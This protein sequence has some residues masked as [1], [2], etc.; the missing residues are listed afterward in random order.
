LRLAAEGA[1][2]VLHYHRNRKAAE[3]T[4]GLLGPDT[5]VLQADLASAAEIERMFRELAG[6]E[7]DILVNN[8]GIWKAEFPRVLAG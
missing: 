6:T 4:V 3:E 2:V 8:A 7:L 5:R 1:E